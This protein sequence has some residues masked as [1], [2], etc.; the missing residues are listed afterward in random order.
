MESIGI[1]ISDRHHFMDG[2]FERPVYMVPSGTLRIQLRLRK[3]IPFELYQ[4][5]KEGLHQPKVEAIELVVSSEF[6][7]LT[8]NEIQQYLKPVLHELNLPFHGSIVL[9]NDAITFLCTDEN[10]EDLIADGADEMATHLAKFG[11][12]YAITTKRITANVK[13]DEVSRPQPTHNAVPQQQN[14]RRKSGKLE[15]YTPVLL[16]N[17]TDGMENIRVKGKIFSIEN[18]MIKGNSTLRQT[19]YIHDEDDAISCLRYADDEASQARFNELKTGIAVEVFGNARYDKYA[20][21]INLSL[22]DIQV[23]P[24]WMKREDNSP[25]KR[26]ELHLH[27]KMSEMDGVST[28][29]EYIQ[30]A[31]DW[32][33]E[34]IAITDHIGVQAFPKAQAYIKDV[35]KKFPDKKF[36]MIYGVEMNMVDPI[37]NIVSTDDPRTLRDASYVV[38]DLETTGLSNRYDWIIEFGAVRIKQGAV[39]ERMQMFVKPPVAISA[40]IT[41]KTNITQQD[42]ENAAVESDLLDSWLKFFKDDVLVA[43]NATF[44][45]GFMNAVLRRYGKPL[46]TNTVIDTLD[47][48]RAVLK[49]RRSYKLGNVA[50]NYKIAYDEEIAHRADYDAEMLSQ[51]FL[52]ILNEPAVAKCLRVGDL[53]HIQDAGAFKKVMKNHVIVLAKNQQGLKDL[54]ELITLSH[55]DRLATLG[56][57]KKDD[58]ESLAEPRILRDDLIAKRTNL[59]LG[60]ACYNGEIFDLA[61]TKSSAE[62]ETAMKFYDYIEVQPPENY[63]P[64][65]ESNAVPDSDRILTILRDLIATAD[66]LQIP[67]LATGDAH[68]VQ[69]AQKRFR[70]IYIQ[71]QGIG[72]VRHPL[73]IYNAQRRH[74]TVMPDQ[75]FRTTDEMFEAFNFLDRETTYRLIIDTPKYIAEKIE[76]AYPVKDRLYTPTIEGADLKLAEICRANALKRYGNPL[77]AIVEERLQKE[78]DSIIGHGFAVV[79]YIAHLLVKKSLEDGYL[80]GSRGSVGSSLVATMTDITEVNPLAP[81][82]VCPVC[83]YSEFT[84]DENIGSGYDLP[85]KCCPKCGSLM[86]GDGQD[87]PFET[88]LGFEG[89]KVPDID[90]NF[91]G[92]YQE[93]AHAYTKV[94]FGE[95]NVYRAGTIG[96]VAQKTAFGYLRGYEEEMEVETPRRLAYNLYI[97]NGCEGIKRT[98]GQ[99][100]GGIIVIPQDMDVSDFTPVQYPANNANSEWLTTHFE[101]ADIHDNV[102]KLDI[103]GHVDPT[104]MKMLEKYSGIDPKTIPMNDPEVISVFSSIAPLHLDPRNYGEK[105]GAAGLPEFGTTFVRQ[106]LEATQPQSF[107]D[108]VR[109][110]GLSHGTDVW[111][112]NARS[113]VEQGLHLREVIG[114]RDD[115]MVSLIHMGLPSKKAF[116]IMESVRRGR[117]LKDEWKTL[118]REKNVP[119]WYIESCLKI[120]YMFP[121]AH[122]VAYVLMAVRVAWFKVHHPEYYYAVF[123]TLRCTSYEIETMIKGAESINARMRDITE[124][125]G[126]NELKKSVTGKEQDLMTTLE[127]AYEMACRGLH[128]ANIDLYKSQ[129]NDFIVDEEHRNRIL[130]PFTVLDG[131]G[132]NVAKSIIEA[133]EK[134]P[135]ISKEDLLTRTQLNGTQLRKLE[136]MGVLKGLQDENQMSLF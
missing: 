49:D 105:T 95:K 14:Y 100:P 123:F 60:S 31:M 83:Q 109:V 82:Y 2:T 53:Q 46:L 81:H 36:K 32:G 13:I 64:L 117:G 112:G 116:D 101:F 119:E 102:L 52:K 45:I 11:I 121:K 51:I 12:P 75:H 98:T 58:E 25:E 133:R 65:V 22:R 20:R 42:V 135:F 43:H 26:I 114:C 129:A 111:L 92:D 54:F 69:Q 130:P 136:V 88:F 134:A 70:E 6:C 72:G 124:R 108:L 115:I 66:R 67:V 74:K 27:T 23:V 34:A 84:D 30:Q 127:V 57:A 85:D 38:F 5:I 16:K 24:D 37:L 55:T 99:H 17:I 89:D 48:S 39:V 128:F 15:D 90:L 120:K 9:E 91:S 94:L 80:V 93:K 61:M 29:E 131:L 33:H 71:A 7:D 122:A 18:Q 35:L 97:A 107:S 79:Y 19:I 21:D 40:F 63:R 4:R 103:L 113:L 41:E 47:L 1:K 132:L 87:I 118:M 50:R 77:P 3:A 44:D 56:K 62:L 8:I 10:Q 78:L 28:I 96:T 126:D 86:I 68:Y 106:I 104:A 76:Q 110:S 125:L 73:Y 59:L